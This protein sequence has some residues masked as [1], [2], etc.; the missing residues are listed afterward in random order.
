MDWA[1]QQTA[2]EKWFKK[3]TGLPV[4]WTKQPAEHNRR[5][6]AELWVN[7]FQSVGED[8]LRSTLDEDATDGRDLLYE[9]C[10]HRLFILTCK[11][12]SRDNRP[13]YHA[14]AYLEKA[15]TSLAK[16]STKSIF[17]DAEIAL[18]N[19]EAV[20]ELPGLFDGR[21]ES[22]ASMDI[23]LSTVVNESDESEAGTYINTVEITS[24]IIDIDGNSLANSLQFVEEEMP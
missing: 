12:R 6:C 23:R 13:G 2:I 17:S 19:A 22:F 3:A 1:T 20:A 5:P 11:V 14:G 8:E 21:E 10:G 15:R 18:I 9:V 24:N 4:E 16:P 7:T